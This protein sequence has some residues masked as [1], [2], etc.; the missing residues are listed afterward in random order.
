[1]YYLENLYFQLSETRKNS[2]QTQSSKGV[3]QGGEKD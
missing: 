3:S 1:M 2:I